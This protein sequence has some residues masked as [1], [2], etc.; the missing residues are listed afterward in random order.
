MSQP[1]IQHLPLAE[2]KPYENNPR[3][4]EAAAEVVARS[5]QTFGVQIPLILDEEHT[6]ICGHTR[7][8]AAQT[9][10]LET[11]PCIIISDLTEAKI[12][13]LRLV[14]N[15]VAEASKWDA[16]LLRSELEAITSIDMA[17]LF[18]MTPPSSEDLDASIDALND[19]DP[20]PAAEQEDTPKTCTCEQCGKTFTI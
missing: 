18:G 12:T 11:L 20:E 3:N 14:D 2:I 17:D 19:I 1:K 8:K 7:L 4:N 15:K 5:M 10:G 6:I 16:A 13:A 9:L